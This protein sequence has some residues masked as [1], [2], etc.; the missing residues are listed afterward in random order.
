MPG[1]EVDLPKGPAALTEANSLKAVISHLGLH[2]FPRRR[3]GRIR[4][5]CL[6]YFRHFQ[7][8]TSSSS[9][10]TSAYCTHI[11]RY[12]HYTSSMRMSRHHFSVKVLHVGRTKWIEPFEHLSECM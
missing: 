1:H 5:L 10:E 7:S 4:I 2:L 11:D 6:A 12:F 9:L 3:V 8:V